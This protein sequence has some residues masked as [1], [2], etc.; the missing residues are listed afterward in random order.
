MRS[1]VVICEIGYGS[2]SV[3]RRRRRLF[4]H[5]SGAF[6]R[7]EQAAIVEVDGGELWR[8]R[9]TR[10]PRR[11]RWAVG[12]V[13]ADARTG[14]NGMAVVRMRLGC[15]WAGIRPAMSRIVGAALSLVPMAVQQRIGRTQRPTA[16]RK[17]WRS[18]R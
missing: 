18:R 15:V 12:R 8:G 6:D 11:V 10:T 5:R 1:A 4:V 14:V 9:S 16:R 2:R 13:V 7:T 3:R 17:R